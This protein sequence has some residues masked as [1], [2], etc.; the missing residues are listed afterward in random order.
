[1]IKM[2]K[3]ILNIYRPHLFKGASRMKVGNDTTN[4]SYIDLS[5]Q[6]PTRSPL[7]H[8]ACD[9]ISGIKCYR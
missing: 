4:F 9:A 6:G 3:I 7:N 2:F 1:M 5:I 8:V